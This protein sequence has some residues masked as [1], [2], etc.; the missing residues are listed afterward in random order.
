LDDEQFV[1]GLPAM[2]VPDLMRYAGADSP[3]T[4]LG[5]KK[6]TS[7]QPLNNSP[8]LFGGAGL[9]SE[10]A[11][12]FLISFSASHP[13]LTAVPLLLGSF[14]LLRAFLHKARIFTEQFTAQN[15]RSEG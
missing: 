11:V 6:S 14:T 15:S 1:N 2:P 10:V 3:K 8:I 4:R 13:L 9:M 12:E 7:Q 5:T